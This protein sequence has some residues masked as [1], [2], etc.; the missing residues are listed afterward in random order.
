M[1]Y[2]Q[3]PS[4]LANA[5]LDNDEY[6]TAH[7]V[8]FEK[9]TLNPNY[10]GVSSREANTYTYITDA[11][12]D[13]Q[14]DDG[15]YSRIEQFQLE[16]DEFTNPGAVS[17]A[18]PNGVQTYRANK[19]LSVGTVNE[20]IEAKAS[21][22]NLKLDSSSLG[23]S[24]YGEFLTVSVGPDAT[25][26][27]SAYTDISEFGFKEGD[28]IKVTNDAGVGGS[29]LDKYGIIDR[30]VY[31]VV[32]ALGSAPLHG[33]VLKRPADLP[34][35]AGGNAVRP[36]EISLVSEE[37]STLVL[38][39]G[40]TSYTNYI[41][42]EVYIYR[43]FINPETNE[44]I[45]GVPVF[46]QGNYSSNGAILVFKGIISN[47]NL[48][49]RPG[50]SSE[51][52]W[53]LSSHW[54]DFVRVQNRITQ[55]ADHR[56]VGVTGLSDPDMILKKE[57]EGDYGFEHSETSLNLIA[58]YNRTET[59][60]KLK[61]KKKNF[62]LSK[63]YT[64]VEYEVEIPT[65]VDL[66]INMQAK[67]LP[68]VYGVQKIDSIPV[69]FDNFKD[70]PDRVYVA[71]ALCEGT[72][73]GI[74]DLAI[75]DKSTLCLDA[76]DEV[77]RSEQ[78]ENNSIDV[79]C[80]GRQDRGDTLRGTDASDGVGIYV[81]KTYNWNQYNAAQGG[82]IFKPAKNL[83]PIENTP[84]YTE[85]TLIMDAGGVATDLD[86]PN[87]D[88]GIL[89][90]EAYAFRDPIDCTLIFHQ[91]RD[92][93]V[94]NNL[95]VEKADKELFKIQNDFYKGNPHQ[96]WTP[97]HRLLDTAYVVGEYL[98]SEGETN[99]PS[100]DFV[101]RGKAIDCYNYDGSF[102]HSG[103]TAAS[104]ESP[105]YF[106]AGDEVTISGDGI[107]TYTTTI[108]DKWYFKDVDGNTQ[109]RF[110]WETEPTPV[111]GA[112]IVMSRSGGQTWT[113]FKADTIIET[114]EIPGELSAEIAASSMQSDGVDITLQN[115]AD[116]F[117]NA[118]SAVDT[119]KQIGQ[120]Q[121]P[122][123][124]FGVL[125]FNNIGG[126][127]YASGDNTFLKN[128]NL[129]YGRFVPGT[130][131]IENVGGIP[132]PIL[133][134]DSG[135]SPAFDKI[136][137]RNAIRFPAGTGVIDEGSYIILSRFDSNNV[138]Y[139]QVRKIIDWIPDSSYPV[140]IVDT[141]WDAD[142]YPQTGD[143]FQVKTPRDQRVS[144]NPAMQLLDYLK[145]ERYG[146]GLS[147]EEIDLETFKTAA[148]ACDTRSDI[149]ITVPSNHAYKFQTTGSQS[150]WRYRFAGLTLWQGTVKSIDTT[151]AT[152]A[153]I[154]FTDCIGKLVQKWTD[155]RTYADGA[156]VWYQD[157]DEGTVLR[158]K[159][160]TGKISD[161][162]TANDP[163][164]LAGTGFNI[165]TV[166][167]SH[168]APVDT[169]L[170][171]YSADGNPIIKNIDSA[172]T[173]TASGYSLYDS[174]NIKYWRLLG[175]DSPSQRNV[176]RHQLN[177]VID[178]SNTVFSNV[179]NMLRQFN[180][181][182]RYS[183]GRYQLRVKSASSPL[184]IYEKISE[185]DIIGAVKLSDKGS[186]KTYNSVSASIIDPQNKFETRSVSFFNSDYLREDNGVPKKG[187]FATPSI[188]NYY[189]A[190]VN[191]KQFLD[192]SRNGLEIQFTARPSGSLLMAGEV[193]GLS[194]ER[195]GWDNKLWRVTNL[196]FLNDGN[197]SV[198]AEEHSDSAY[199]VP[200]P[201]ESIPAPTQGSSG[202]ILSQKPLPP[203]SLTA[204][205]NLDSA[206]ILNWKNP[207]NYRAETHSV[208]VYRSSYNKRTYQFNTPVNNATGVTNL[209]ELDIPMGNTAERADAL[210]M[211]EGMTIQ[212]IPK[213][214]NI[215]LTGQNIDV[216]R[217]YRIENLGDE[218]WNQ[219]LGT[220][221]IEYAVGSVVTF[222][223]TNLPFS[224]NNLARLQT[225]DNE[226]YRL[227]EV[228]IHPNAQTTP[229]I[230]LCRVDKKVKQIPNSI[231]LTFTAP[232][233]ATVVDADT[234]TDTV[235][236]G[237]GNIERFYWVRY[238]VSRN[239]IVNAG[240]QTNILY[241]D[242]TPFG[243][244]NG[245][246]GI[247][248]RFEST[249]PRD[250][251]LAFSAPLEFVYT[252]IG[253]TIESGFDTSCV[254]T[255]S[256]VNTAGTVEW[257]FE[258]I[259][260]SGTT[261]SQAYSASNTFTFNAPV[262]A[263]R[264]AGFDMMPQSV[265]VKMR[266]STGVPN[267]YIERNRTVSF[268]ATRILADGDPGDSVDM[269]FLG[270]LTQPS[271]P[272]ASAGT[273]SGWYTDVSSAQAAMTA[274]QVLFASVGTKTGS[275]SNFTW[276][277][278]IQIIGADGD[279]GVAIV[280][281][282][283]YRRSVSQL[284][285]PTGGSFNFN[286]QTLTV[287]TSWS[288]GVPP[289]N[290]PVYVST[291]IAVSGTPSA[292]AATITWSYPVIAF[293]DG[294]DGDPGVDSIKVD[295]TNS[296]HSIP[297]QL[298]GTYDY[299]GSGTDVYV[300]EGDD[301][302]N[303]DTTPA[304]ND[305]GWWNF[306]GTTGSNVT[307]ASSNNPTDQGS[308]A[309]FADHT[310][311][312]DATAYV[313]FN[314]QGKRANG[315]N[316]SRIAYQQLTRLE[317][318]ESVRLL[319]SAQSFE[320]GNAGGV[321]PA[322]YTLTAET[323]GIDTSQTY[324][325]KFESY[326][327][328]TATLLQNTVSNSVSNL[329]SPSSY[330]NVPD[331]Y[332][333]SVLEGSNTGPVVATDLEF[334]P[335]LKPGSAIGIYATNPIHRFF[336]TETGTASNNYET[337]FQVTVDGTVY[338]YDEGSGSNLI[339]Y[340]MTEAFEQDGDNQYELVNVSIDSNETTGVST[341]WNTMT[342]DKVVLADGNT[343]RYIRLMTQDSLTAPDD[344]N[345]ND[346]V[347]SLLNTQYTVSC[348]FKAG[349]HDYVNLIFGWGTNTGTVTN[350][351]SIDLSNGSV[352]GTSLLNPSV[353]YAVTNEGNGWYRIA[354]T[355][356]P[357]SNY[358]RIEI[359]PAS[360]NSAGHSYFSSSGSKYFYASGLQ[361]VAASSAAS[362]PVSRTY[363]ANT[364]RY[365]SLTFD[366]NK[367]V[368]TISPTGD[369]VITL[370]ANSP[371]LSGTS[372][373]NASFTVPIIDNATDSTLALVPVNIFKELGNRAS[374]EFSFDANASSSTTLGFGS[375][376][377]TQWSTTP[378]IPT[379]TAGNNAAR[380][381]A[382]LVLGAPA[383][384]PDII[385]GDKVT[386]YN[387][388]TNETV[389]RIYVGP[390]RTNSTV[391]ATTAS[392]WSTEVALVVPGS[393]IIQ[394]TLDANRL[395]ASTISADLTVSSNLELSNTG[396]I[397]TTNKTSFGDSSLGIFL[398]YD[399]NAYKFDIGNNDQYL[400]FDGTNIDLKCETFSLQSDT[401]ASNSR[402]TIIDDRLEVYDGSTLRVR[403]GRL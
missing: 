335:G 127:M 275:A 237:L 182:L 111:G 168:T 325:Y 112:E 295:L 85:E 79:I 77:A 243:I 378:S 309:R 365:G 392:D 359:Q 7:L 10:N 89:H 88:I 363:G 44:I 217:Q 133:P 39:N 83:G 347:G 308:F 278:P 336:A 269:I 131:K 110:R 170:N 343:Q 306:T 166:S 297:K 316:F 355:A 337:E 262:G 55:D 158:R 341:P 19:L 222:G 242:F 124:Y 234:F 115:L 164:I 373:L 155:Y 68:V 241:S 321:S 186:K 24:V 119:V 173:L 150:K 58:T 239:V 350:R 339:P 178:T 120:Y 143:K 261:V 313:E 171:G 351:V 210:T 400:R 47:A 5:L 389:T 386:I 137:L 145:S 248:D 381:A 202:S 267:Q 268:T 284:S 61:K 161:F 368:P 340:T 82:S 52:N 180:G 253:Q 51:M 49:E 320:F 393:A 304:S 157:V 98:L 328:A 259:T 332:K 372:I 282:N 71:Y 191:I 311:I 130:N 100:L 395:T 104:S 195:F 329:T 50:K 9:P 8:K 154:T 371:I 317:V 108:I 401:V 256:G 204:S 30:F 221:G 345:F 64:Q 299:S 57:Y 86:D 307:L 54:G 14:F 41:N 201:D 314:I 53:T 38:G 70:Q 374:K 118:A 294:S 330:G 338:S 285:T 65:D 357:A 26:L 23:N 369:G 224:G 280:E 99:M 230:I 231:P 385:S 255:A 95:L 352:L 220:T 264:A 36:N 377:W 226:E 134:A 252:K 225:M 207:S 266:E 281:L 265:T 312:S 66:N 105:S 76:F 196:N 48:S 140:A 356:T 375:T 301:E 388:T 149:T 159:Q 394:G 28:T 125:A 290:Q 208:E 144:I 16:K 37:L 223:G 132:D 254:I 218:N 42:R 276:Q 273:P 15:S 126:N 194:Y 198:T 45:G 296:N 128:S 139:T 75:D 31:E 175:W 121:Q 279:P 383:N 174:D 103:S 34:F 185:S 333:V 160:G 211:V 73:G 287:P 43:I 63:K 188:T 93:Q 310:A 72:I 227:E 349:T 245:V 136:F 56:A 215:T 152:S 46:H 236:E 376:D 169:G 286:T 147:E 59:R 348:H 200:A 97:N 11:P 370:S 288:D 91:G 209:I 303:Y 176:T 29:Q 3:Y 81:E 69:F 342:H 90:E 25:M 354:I 366:N 107:T 181:I 17:T 300:Y 116:G 219:I 270:A 322:S 2:R 367:A 244:E 398:G 102:Q 122:K 396:K 151:S 203:S 192:E 62:G 390:N 247:A 179:N 302:L 358:T 271:T 380:D 318:P 249:Q 4:Q 146:K 109:Y 362:Y 40:S 327:G 1:A 353:T 229:N 346:D 233:I 156:L 113:M 148:V 165:A 96:Y 289:G 293:Q 291:G 101:V 84:Y 129:R 379:T 403:L 94:A 153:I 382:K 123:S 32:P 344:A 142:Y 360:G 78:N 214:T 205:Q 216:G 117:N 251:N 232:K 189:N 240:V 277:T 238:K 13:I 326:V 361:M 92:N 199:F 33:V 6:V 193:F 167:G 257:Q 177:Q 246:S 274:G 397:Y 235:P 228:F 106:D 21:S 324:F 184:S 315:T 212:G 87:L 305:V 190:R 22:M 187:S 319:S 399:T 80:Q 384:S 20:G 292:T 162:F 138:P 272:A 323:T 334:I 364:Y 263:N 258:T 183:N 18:V 331:Y 298:D 114:G 60:T 141:P 135:G 163:Q 283:I 206:I 391:S 35:L 67:A 74:L 387:L 213:S 250:I 402:L 260:T 27:Y 12:Y 197:V 172:G